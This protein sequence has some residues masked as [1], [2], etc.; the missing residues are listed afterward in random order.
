[1]ARTEGWKYVQ[2]KRWWGR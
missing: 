2:E 1:M